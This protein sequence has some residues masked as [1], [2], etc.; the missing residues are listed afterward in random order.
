MVGGELKWGNRENPLGA[1]WAMVRTLVF[2]L[3][4]WEPWERCEQRKNV[5]DLRF[6]RILLAA[7]KRTD[8]GDEGRSRSFYGTSERSVLTALTPL[9]LTYLL[10]SLAIT[11]LF[12]HRE[13][14]T[15]G[16]LP[17]ENGVLVS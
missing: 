16:A 4:E 9:S 10:Q 15:E 11:P 12:S 3:S 1:F 6:N 14:S 13:K 17:Q 5:P 7:M 8:C 2:A